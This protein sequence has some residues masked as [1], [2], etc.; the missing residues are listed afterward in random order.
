MKRLKKAINQLSP[1][2]ANI[3]K[4]RHGF[5]GHDKL[6]RW[7]LL[8]INNNLQSVYMAKKL[9]D[10]AAAKVKSLIEE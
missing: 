6:E 9:Y 5:G 3:F 4:D 10:T 7:N 8:A 2:E 1:T